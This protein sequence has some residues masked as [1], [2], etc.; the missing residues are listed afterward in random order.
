MATPLTEGPDRTTDGASSR[1]ASV[2]AVHHALRQQIL[3]G[4]IQSGA[5]LSQ[6]ELAERFGVSR[7]P[8]REALRML[9]EEGLIDAKGRRARVAVFDLKDLEAISA[10]RILLTALA[11]LVTVPGMGDGG[12]EA[13]RRQMSEMRAATAS[14][15]V[16]AWKAADHAF[17]A[18]H[19][20][21]APARIIQ[22]VGRLAERNTLYQLVWLRDQPHRDPQ[23]E[24]E[25]ERILAACQRRD[26]TEVARNV[27]R[28]QARIALTVMAQAAPEHNPAIIRAALQLALGAD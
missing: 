3:D 21:G 25:H 22:E 23:T 27:A 14:G 2:V 5:V 1:S 13:L 18:Q 28:H 26:A 9:Q 6:V 7:T 20:A 16:R 12:L 17:H 11:S 10:Q 19:C 15:D 24:T 4:S 8:L